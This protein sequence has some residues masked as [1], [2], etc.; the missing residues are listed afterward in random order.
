M[1]GN[2]GFQTCGGYFA[3]AEKMYEHVLRAHM[4]QAPSE[5][6]RFQNKEYEYRCRWADCRK[7]TAPTK[8]RLAEFM[9]HIK[10]HSCGGGE[11]RARARVG[12]NGDATLG[13]LS[14][15]GGGGGH[16]RARKP[17]VV[18]AKTISLAYE[19]TVTTRDAAL[20]NAPPQAAGIPLSAVLVLRNIARNVGKD[21]CGG[22]TV[23]A[24]RGGRRRGQRLEREA[25]P[26]H[27]PAPLRDHDGEQGLGVVHH[28]ALPA[29]PRR[30]GRRLPGR[31]LV[32]GPHL[33]S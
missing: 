20:P 11:N 2:R 9:A 18:P 21:R 19:E 5:D 3:S 27:A 32:S 30:L 28:V 1:V 17:Y 29:H 13:A 10:T 7:Y 15:S 16:K 8:M 33:D 4:G 12:S 6:G 31:T 24:E 23:Q 25:L 22:G 26:V 14:N